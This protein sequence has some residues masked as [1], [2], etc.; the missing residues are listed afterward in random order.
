MIILYYICQ[1]LLTSNIWFSAIYKNHSLHNHS[2]STITLL[3]SH[4]NI[5]KKLTQDVSESTEQE[6]TWKINNKHVT[7][8]TN[9]N[10]RLHSVF[11]S[12]S[13]LVLQ[14]KTYCKSDV[15][16]SIHVICYICYSQHLS[17]GI[18]HCECHQS[19]MPHYLKSARLQKHSLCACFITQ[20]HNSTL[21][22]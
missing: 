6:G 7:D 9:R 5:C 4:W 17:P 3:S 19:A 15:L 20:F 12:V 2:Y 1:M 21:I 11:P 13:C 16:A 10:N 18:C 8:R 14:F 22:F